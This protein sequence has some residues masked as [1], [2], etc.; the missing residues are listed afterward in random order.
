MHNFSYLELKGDKNQ[1]IRASLH[2]ANSGNA[3]WFIF[4]H[5]FTSQRMGPGY[6]F[7][8]LSRALAESGFSSVRFDFRGSG[9]SDGIFSEMNV[10]TMKQDLLIV[11]SWLKKEYKPSAIFLLGHSFG[12]MIAAL[13]SKDVNGTVLLA[14]VADPQKLIV[15]QKKIV[16]SGPNAE[17]YYEHGPHE[18]DASFASYLLEIDP[19]EA[20]CKNS[21]GP[22]LLIQGDND[23]SISVEESASYITA[24]NRSGIDSEYHIFKGADHNFSRVS[25]VK[26]LCRTVINWAKERAL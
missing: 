24:A 21:E 12:G 1:L 14:P 23:K 13:C 9:E 11:I 6:L 20:L 2:I 7:V 15:N 16:E 25:D 10:S 26:M 18:M 17:G 22:L 5:G 3:P 19:V 4:C 8:K